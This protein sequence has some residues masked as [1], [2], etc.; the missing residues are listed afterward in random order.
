[1]AKRTQKK[2]NRRGKGICDFDNTQAFSEG[3]ALFNDGDL[4]KLDESDVFQSDDEAVR[5][6]ASRAFC[7]SAYHQQALVLGLEYLFGPLSS[8]KGA[9]Q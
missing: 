3:W 4:Q 1:M 8:K 5:F 2:P 6:V 7:G 9:A